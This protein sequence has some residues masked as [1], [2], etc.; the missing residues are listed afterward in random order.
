MNVRR[1]RTLHRSYAS[2]NRLL[3]M[4]VK[5]LLFTA[6]LVAAFLLLNRSSLP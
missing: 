5:V 1:R 6:V 4:A 2:P 3:L